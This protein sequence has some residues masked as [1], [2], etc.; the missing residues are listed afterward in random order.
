MVAITTPQGG[1]GCLPTPRG[2]RR[3]YIYGETI[4]LHV[5]CGRM[6]CVVGCSSLWL[7]HCV[8]GSR[9]GSS[10][11]GDWRVSARV[12]P[13]LELVGGIRVWVIAT[14]DITCTVVPS[15]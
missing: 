6:G 4:L 2:D 11:S 8:C 13:A 15:A 3:A 10:C 7:S 5:V 14:C 9:R 1:G 12:G